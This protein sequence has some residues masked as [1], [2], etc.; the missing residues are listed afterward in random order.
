MI[1]FDCQSC[2]ACCIHS[3][4]IVVETTDAPPPNHL[5]RS[6]RGRIGFGSWEA[7]EGTRVMARRDCNGCAA[8]SLKK[9]RYVC[10]IY[11]RR[12]AVCREFQSGSKECLEARALAGFQDQLP[13]T[14]EASPG[15]ARLTE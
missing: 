8:L 4:E 9:G 12:P 14:E 6:V 5:T 3:G 10:R 1:E 2:G 7:D 11:E 15:S 13:S